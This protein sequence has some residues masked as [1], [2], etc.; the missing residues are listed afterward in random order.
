MKC[1]NEN[2][3]EVCRNKDYRFLL[4]NKALALI[5]SVWL[6]YFLSSFT[7]IL[8]RVIEKDGRDLKPP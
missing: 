8:Y 2:N 6:S 3:L 7:E 5:A 4:T 1:G